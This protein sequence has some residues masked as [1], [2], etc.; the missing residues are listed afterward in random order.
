MSF[1][2]KLEISNRFKKG[3][4]T[5]AVLSIEFSSLYLTSRK[6]REIGQHL[7]PQWIALYM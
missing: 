2:T 4:A 7:L 3:E 1:I 6:V 5:D